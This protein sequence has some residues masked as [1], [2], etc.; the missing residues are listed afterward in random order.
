M[1]FSLK[2]KRTKKKFKWVYAKRATEKKTL[3]WFIE[4]HLNISYRWVGIAT[5]VATMY[6][7]L[8]HR[9]RCFIFCSL[10]VVSC[11][12]LF[13]LLCVTTTL[14]P[15][16]SII[17]SLSFDII[18][19]TNSNLCNTRRQN[20]ESVSECATHIKKSNLSFTVQ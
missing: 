11:F 3:L 12:F 18:Y 1:M 6:T 2:K 5:T 14:F 13:V 4:R 7:H 19:F 9:A 16:L 10:P 8:I 15:P 17:Y 20:I